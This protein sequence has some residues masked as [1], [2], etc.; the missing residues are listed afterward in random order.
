MHVLKR[1]LGLGVLGGVLAV[2]LVDSTS[3]APTRRAGPGE[4][5]EY[6][7]WHQGHCVDA[8]DA[9]GKAWPAGIPTSGGPLM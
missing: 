6:K 9:P 1:V 5:G 7:Y 3:A 4:C 2:A 8:R